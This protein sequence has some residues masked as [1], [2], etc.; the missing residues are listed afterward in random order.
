MKKVVEKS[1]QEISTIEHNF[2]SEPQAA[3][4]EHTTA[5]GR[6]TTIADPSFWK[7]VRQQGAGQAARWRGHSHGDDGELHMAAPGQR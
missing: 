5:L 7:H 1:K 6:Q 4:D 3:T 2:A